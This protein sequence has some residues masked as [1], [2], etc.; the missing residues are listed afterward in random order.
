MPTQLQSVCVSLENV[1]LSEITLQMQSL[2]FNMERFLGCLFKKKKKKPV[3]SFLLDQE[4][5]LEDVIIQSD[6]VL[7]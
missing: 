6:L 2:K 7:H 4:M 1:C 5:Y 3:F